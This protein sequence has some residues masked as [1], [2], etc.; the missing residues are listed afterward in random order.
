MDS[1]EALAFIKSKAD[2]MGWEALAA[3]MNMNMGVIYA[4]WRRGNVPDWRLQAVEA[5]AKK[6]NK[7]KAA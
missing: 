1:K 4:W 5:A 2:E 6:L 7:R 3:A